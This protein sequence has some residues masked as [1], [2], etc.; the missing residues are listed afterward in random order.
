[1]A[2]WTENEIEE[3][4]GK[5]TQKSMTDAEFRKEVLEDANKALE[6]L[7]GKPL[8]PGASLKCIEKDPNYQTTLVL[9]DLLDEEKL[10]DEALTEVAGGIN[11]ALIV[12]VC[13]AA[14]GVGPSFVGVCGA[15]GCVGEV[16]CTG[17]ACGAH[18][19]A[20]N[21][22]CTGHACGSKQTPGGECQEAACGSVTC[23]EYYYKNGVGPV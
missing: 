13:A 1:M 7:A 20:G 3:L 18:G 17:A 15:Q 16:I 10:N 21:T 12:N 6:K 14:A 11:I 2:K 8:P 4:I 5:M 22:A 19:C 23:A 9:P